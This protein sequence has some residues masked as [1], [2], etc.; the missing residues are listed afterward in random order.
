MTLL[1]II[2]HLHYIFWENRTNKSQIGLLPLTPFNVMFNQGTPDHPRTCSGRIIFMAFLVL[3]VI[4]NAAFSANLIKT[5][6]LKIVPFPFKD[7]E[8]LYHKSDYKALLIEGSAVLDNFRSAIGVPQDLINDGRLEIAES[9]ADGVDKASKANN[10]ALIDSEPYLKSLIGKGC[11][12]QTVR[13]AQ[14]T[15]TLYTRKGYPYL[16]LINFQ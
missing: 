10:L 13:Y 16:G 5:V 6:T 3:G 15:T 9:F 1:S 7:I 12:F 14:P 2:H 8:S 4:V 11:D